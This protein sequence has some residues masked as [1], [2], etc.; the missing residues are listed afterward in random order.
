MFKSKLV[1]QLILILLVLNGITVSQP[2]GSK[3]SVQGGVAKPVKPV[4]SVKP[5][6]PTKPTKTTK[7]TKTTKPAQSAKPTE[8]VR[9][10][11]P[12]PSKPP[13][14]IS[15]GSNINIKNQKLGILNQI[16]GSKGKLTALS[17]SLPDWIKQKNNNPNDSG[18]KSTIAGFHFMKKD[19]KL[20]GYFTMD[21]K[22]DP[23]Q[24][25]RGNMRLLFKTNNDD[26]KKSEVIGLV[27]THDDNVR[28][29]KDV[30]KME[31]NQWFKVKNA[32]NEKNWR[33][34]RFYATKLENSKK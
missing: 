7:T 14:P 22:M 12:T 34:S 9:P 4:Q 5:V 23:N 8:L 2:T 28:K 31:R 27:D 18:T 21:I 1:L 25:Q 17:Y 10:T 24:K 30:P 29:W 16:T 3:K 33:K 20:D 15:Y 6:Q 19:S 32:K 26:I 13:K 11:K